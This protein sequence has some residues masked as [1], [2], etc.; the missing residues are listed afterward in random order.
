MLWKF[1]IPFM[2]AESPLESVPNSR[3]PPGFF[4]FS[5]ADLQEI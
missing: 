2:R 5:R 3:A 4:D 1:D